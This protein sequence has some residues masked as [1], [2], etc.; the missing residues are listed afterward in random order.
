MEV[1]ERDTVKPEHARRALDHAGQRANARE[2]VAEIVE[3]G[4]VDARH[5]RH[6]RRRYRTAPPGVTAVAATHFTPPVAA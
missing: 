1:H 3:S 6:S 2:R 5:R 4:V